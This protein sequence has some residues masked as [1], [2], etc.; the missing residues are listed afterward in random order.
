MRHL[1][2]KLHLWERH[3][4]KWINGRMHNRFL[5]FWL[6]YLTHLGGATSTIVIN[7][8]VWVLAPE[9][10]RTTG[11]QAL[12]AL[13][14]SHIPVAIAKKLYPRMRPYLA[15]PETNTFRNPL[16]DHSFPSGH[17]TAIFAS[18]V[19]Y[20]LAFPALTVILLPLACIVGFSRIYLGLHYP[21]DVIAGAVIGSCVAAG[22]IALWM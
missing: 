20:M 12:T 6:F 11:L 2:M 15:L 7:I 22:T 5:N 17:T 13:A 8:L 4:F 1:F 10:W 19:P 21:S 18:T 16:K 3:L 14:V 9:P